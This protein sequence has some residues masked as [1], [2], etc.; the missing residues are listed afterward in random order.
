M[1]LFM[2]RQIQNWQ[3]FEDK[4][5]TKKQQYKEN[6]N[7]PRQKALSNIE[8]GS[9]TVKHEQDAPKIFLIKKLFGIKNILADIKN[10]M[11]ALLEISQ[12]V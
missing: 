3:A 9:P 5:K 7:F 12:K 4:I 1:P 10:S 11:E 6:R 2:K 8:E